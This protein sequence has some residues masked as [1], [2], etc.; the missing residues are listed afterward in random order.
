M[1]DFKLNNKTTENL[2][3]RCRRQVADELSVHHL[4]MS[5]HVRLRKLAVAERGGEQMWLDDINRTH[6]GNRI[7]AECAI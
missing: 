7:I 4:R 5:R 2:Q 1:M 3:Q 6:G